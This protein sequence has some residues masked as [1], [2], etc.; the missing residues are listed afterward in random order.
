MCHPLQATDITNHKVNTSRLANLSLINTPRHTC[1]FKGMFIHSIKLHLLYNN[2][3][4][5]Q[6]VTVTVF[7]SPGPSPQ[8]VD[9]VRT[10]I[11]LQRSSLDQKQINK[12]IINKLTVD[13]FRLSWRLNADGDPVFLVVVVCRSSMYCQ[14]FT[15]KNT[16]SIL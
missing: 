7:K 14:H 10:A 12:I 11:S 4:K 1:L 9:N 15:D 6:T 2:K 16:V 3:R 13:D 8:Q 5:L